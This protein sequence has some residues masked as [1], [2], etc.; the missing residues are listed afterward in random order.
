MAVFLSISLITQ[1]MVDLSFK[2]LKILKEVIHYRIF[3]QYTKQSNPT[4]F[5]S[6]KYMLNFNL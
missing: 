4:G 1:N 5:H 2:W 3:I 6:F